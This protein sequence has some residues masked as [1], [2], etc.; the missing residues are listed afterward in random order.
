MDDFENLVTKTPHPATHKKQSETAFLPIGITGRQRGT[1][2]LSK[3]HFWK[4]DAIK[5]GCAVPE[6]VMLMST[7]RSL[8]HLAGSGPR[9]HVVS[10]V[11]APF[12]C[13]KGRL[14]RSR[15]RTPEPCDHFAE[16]SLSISRGPG[17]HPG[18]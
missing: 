4:F 12:A 9:R 5:T 8:I 7:W 18:A 15:S 16:L 3:I 2:G 13:T 1:C 10:L 6:C 14:A 11:L 17:L